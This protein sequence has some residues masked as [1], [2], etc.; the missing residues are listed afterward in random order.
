[1]PTTFKAMT[2][3]GYSWKILAELL[4]NNIKTACFEIDSDGIRLRM[5]D[6]HRTILIDLELDA[7]KFSVYKYKSDDKM[8]LGINLTHF[9]KMLKSIKK[10]DSIQLFITDDAPTDL[11]IKVI[12]KENNRVTTSFIKIQTIQNLDIDLPE[13]YGRPVI[14]P[15]S[16]F[17][18]M[19]KGLTHISNETHVTSKGFLIRFSSDAGGVMKRFTEFGEAEDT[20]S[21]TE[22]DKD[23][24][25][26]YDEKFDTE[27]LTRVTKLAGLHTAMQI[28]PKQENPLLIRS[29]V[30]SIGRISI[31]LK[32]K[33]LQAAE[34]AVA[35]SD[36]E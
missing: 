23:D 30:G 20:D 5:M 4:H 35:E 28:Y 36:D 15:S 26:E 19:C 1:M 8:Y 14:V 17:Q 6:H 13:G 12:P 27:Q 32:S 25:P 9:H 11:G 7:D 22:E 10:R 2:R 34:S 3:D 21:D 16:E 18:K 29:D 33:S 31:Y 24:S